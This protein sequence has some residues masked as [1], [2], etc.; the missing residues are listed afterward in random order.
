MLPAESVAVSAAPLAPGARASE[1]DHVPSSFTVASKGP[2]LTL[3]PSS[4]V[5][6]IST[7]LE[8][9]VDPSS[10]DVIVND[11]GVVSAGVL[12]APAV[13]EAD[14]ASSWGS[15]ASTAS[16]ASL[17]CVVAVF[18]SASVTR[19]ARTAE[20]ILADIGA[21]VAMPWSLV[22]VARASDESVDGENAAKPT[23]ATS[24]MMRRLAYAIG[25]RGPTRFR[26]CL[27]RFFMQTR[28][29]SGHMRVRID[30]ASVGGCL[31]SGQDIS[32]TE[33]EQAQRWWVDRSSP[34]QDSR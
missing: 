31:C 18:V 14:R 5:P 7:I 9:A 20:A 2:E 33:I 13:V 32:T 8:L 11:G 23:T 22:V 25:I 3:A 19:I 6:L 21:D 16:G 34:C 27:V 26:G 1:I 12:W 17:L 28:F 29:V 24:A 15:S 30:T 4:T 10:G